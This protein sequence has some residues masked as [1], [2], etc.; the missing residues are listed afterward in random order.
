MSRKNTKGKP[1]RKD[2]TD[3]LSFIGKK[4]QFLEQLAVAN[5]NIL[6]AYI[7]FKGDKDGFL[8]YLEEKFPAKEGAKEKASS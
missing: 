7:K 8:K 4:L 1:T 6:D 5:E 3:A 2:M